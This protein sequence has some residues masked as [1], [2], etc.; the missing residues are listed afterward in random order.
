MAAN[1]TA[2]KLNREGEN[3]LTG[4][5]LPPDSSHESQFDKDPKTKRRWANSLNHVGGWQSG[6]KGGGTKR[7]NYTRLMPN[8]AGTARSNRDLLEL[9]KT[10]VKPWNQVQPQAS[11]DGF[12]DHNDQPPPQLDAHDYTNRLQFEDL[13]KTRLEAMCQWK[14][15]DLK[16]T[17]KNAYIKQIQKKNN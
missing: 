15:K 8:P 7:A 14:Q 11:Y 10:Y 16:G 6:E 9:Q 17:K 5:G 4:D 3:F 2:R 1:S 13:Q 12:V